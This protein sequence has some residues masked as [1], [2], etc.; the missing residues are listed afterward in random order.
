MGTCCTAARGAL[1][2][3]A[4]CYNRMLSRPLRQSPAS[5]AEQ[6]K[7]HRSK[8]AGPIEKTARGEGCGPIDPL[9]ISHNLLVS[10]HKL[11]GLFDALDSFL[12]AFSAEPSRNDQEQGGADKVR[13]WMWSELPWLVRMGDHAPR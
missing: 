1:W 11:L 10:E 13:G 2:L 9:P 8:Q 4:G 12:G 7:R 3:A 6:G 5:A